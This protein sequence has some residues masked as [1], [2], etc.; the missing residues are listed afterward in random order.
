[1]EALT[2]EDWSNIA[3]VATAIITLVGIIVSIWL[4]TKAL[5]EV[6]LDRRLRSKPHLA[7]EIGGWRLPIQFV[8]IGYHVGGLNPQ[9]V[10][11]VFS[12]LP[13]GAESIELKSFLDKGKTHKLFGYGRLQNHGSGSALSTHISWVANEIW[14]G[15][16]HFDIDDKKRTEPV[17]RKNLNTWPS[18]PSN[19]PAN[20][21]ASTNSLPTFITKDIDKKITRVNGMFEISCRDIFDTH[22][23]VR[24]EFHLF[25]NYRDDPPTVHVT[26]S[27][28]LGNDV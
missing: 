20:G 7:F 25:T 3:R 14:V 11:E 28:I 15:S 13:E 24:Q 9:F 6:Q 8:K 19:I 18:L 26:F 2:L 10:K 23:I 4:S 27:D 12:N 22:H 1:M 16:E 21:E 5:R 17:Y